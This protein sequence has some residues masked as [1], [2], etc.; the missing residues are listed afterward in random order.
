MLSKVLIYGGSSGIGW[1]S[2]QLLHQQGY[3]LH[4]VARD[5]ARLQAK[6]AEIG[7][8]YTVGD[9]M[10]DETFARVADETSGQLAGL[11]Y[12]VGSIRL[13]PLA[14]LTR[15]QMLDDFSLNALGAALAVQ[16][17]LPSLKM[18]TGTASVVLFSSVAASSGFNM[19][20]SIGMAKSAVNGLM[21]SLAAELAPV[22]RVNAIAPSLTATPLA[23]PLLTNEKMAESL[24]KMHP[25][26]RLGTSDD[27]AKMVAYLI[28][29]D[30]SWITGQCFAVDGGRSTLCV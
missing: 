15:Q 30:S 13:A 27:I 19:H 21:L 18:A 7:A 5:E 25:M 10:D 24:A 26:K 1:A 2:A 12:S 23:E 16:A 9:V 11:V 6:A 14:R 29:Q 28:S 22:V 4:L 8:S 3:Q 17:S 20:S